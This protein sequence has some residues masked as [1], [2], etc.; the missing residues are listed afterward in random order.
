MREMGELLIGFAKAAEYVELYRTGLITLKLSTIG[1]QIGILD[2]SGNHTTATTRYISY[3]NLQYYK[4]DLFSLIKTEID[5]AL[6]MVR[7]AKA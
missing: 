2:P 7:R 6:E 5:E 4:G 1:L 3:G